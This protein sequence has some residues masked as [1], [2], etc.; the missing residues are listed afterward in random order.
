MHAQ[1]GCVCGEEEEGT[2]GK[3]SSSAA[4]RYE[5]KEGE[6]HKHEGGGGLRRGGT[7]VRGIRPALTRN[8]HCHSA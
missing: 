3:I 5:M 7:C 8:E 4:E 1:A 6:K 2:G